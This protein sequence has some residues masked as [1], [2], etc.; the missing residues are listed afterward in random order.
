MTSI[1]SFPHTSQVDTENL[2]LEGKL[3]ALLSIPA[4]K[5]EKESLWPG[6]LY[7]SLFLPSGG[8][9]LLVYFAA[10]KAAQMNS[11]SQTTVNLLEFSPKLKDPQKK[12]LDIFISAF[13]SQ[14][15]KAVLVAMYVL[16]KHIDSLPHFIEK[17]TLLEFI[18]QKLKSVP[19]NDPSLLGLWESVEND[20]TLSLLKKKIRNNVSHLMGFRKQNY[21]SHRATVVHALEEEQKKL[22]VHAV[23][24]YIGVSTDLRDLKV[25]FDT[26][27]LAGFIPSELLIQ[28]RQVLLK[29]LEHEQE[30]THIYKMLQ[31]GNHLFISSVFI[32]VAHLSNDVGQRVFLTAKE[33]L[34][35]T[36]KIKSKS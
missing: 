6:F 26:L 31:K 9:D 32:E 34:A 14:N 5:M 36:S 27:F 12:A 22:N 11:A 17:T 15:D 29:F 16:I 20:S 24:E 4:S 10:C 25:R 28:L 21:P 1:N 18:L 35:P 30:A 8:E 3:N 23:T 7:E 19:F 33:V 13:L 2:S